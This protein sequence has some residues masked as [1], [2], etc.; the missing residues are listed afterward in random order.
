MKQ[1]TFY[2]D[3]VSPYAYLAF[4]RLPQELAG[5]SYSVTYQ[6]VL[7]GALLQHHG[8]LAPADVAAKR[9]WLYRHVSW[10]GQQQGLDFS[11]P[12]VHPFN[13]L[14]L[15]RLA[16]ACEAAG[17]PNRHVCGQ[18]FRHVWQGGADAADPARLASLQ[19]ALAP[20]RAPDDADVKQQLRSVTDAAARLGVFGVPAFVVDGKLFWGLDALPMLRACLAGDAW[21]DGPQW[22]QALPLPRV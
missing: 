6:P 15:L 16:L 22:D 18:I 1:I 5:L 17:Q 3:F 20:P 19:A 10:L 9:A 8:N 7:L 2:L 21:F 14:P 11:M 13:P 4:E 12:L